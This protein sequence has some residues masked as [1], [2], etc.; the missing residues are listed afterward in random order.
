MVDSHL[1]RAQ[2]KAFSHWIADEGGPSPVGC[3][4]LAPRF[5]TGASC[6]TV[7]AT[8]AYCGVLVGSPM[9]EAYW[10]LQ[11]GPYPKEGRAL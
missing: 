11:W 5:I 4:G 1:A 10:D 6:N 9:T 7:Y 3:R 2:K 8:L